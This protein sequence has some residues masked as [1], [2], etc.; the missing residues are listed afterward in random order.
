MLA[1]V[2]ALFLG[3]CNNL[4]VHDE[5]RGSVVKYAIYTENYHAE[6]VT[7]SRRALKCAV[8]LSEKRKL[9]RSG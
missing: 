3:S 5:R 1:P 8:I 2:K 9:K 7:E 4:T 6:K